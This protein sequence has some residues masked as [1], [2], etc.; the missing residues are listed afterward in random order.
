MITVFA[1]YVYAGTALQPPITY[2]YDVNRCRYFAGRLMRQPPIPG[3]KKQKITA[4]CKLQQVKKGT[5][6]YK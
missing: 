6:I 2:W 3:E 1:L 4:V 5:E